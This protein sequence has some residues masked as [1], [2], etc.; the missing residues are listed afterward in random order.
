MTKFTKD[1]EKA[2]NDR[3]RDIL[4]SASA[5]SGKTTVLVERVLQEIMAGT[6]VDQLLVVTFTKAAA[7]EMKNRIKQAITNALKQKNSDTRYLRREL[8]KV[9]TAN[10]STIDAFCLDVIHRFYYVIDLDPS[11]SIL[12]DE[13]QAALLKERA[14]HEVESEYLEEKNQDFIAFYDNFAGDRDAAAPQELLLDLYDFALA[15][16]NYRNWL[17]ELSRAYDIDAEIV[18]SNLWQKEIKPY[19][20]T[21]FSALAEKI[22]A[23]LASSQMNTKELAKVYESFQLF[24]KLLANYLKALRADVSYD[25]QREL[26]QSCI[27]TGNYR[28]SNKWDEDL[29]DLYQESQDLKNQ[30]KNQIFTAFI[31]FY[32]NNEAEQLAIMHKSQKIIKTIS[33]AELALI[34]RFNEL[35]REENL[36]DYSDMEQFA[37]QILSQDTSKSQL[38]R[39]FYQNKFKEILIDEY[40]DINA[41]QEEILQLLKGPVNN[42]FMVGDVKQSIYGFRQ[43]EPDLF[44][45]KYQTFAQEDKTKERI[46]LADNFR[47]TKPVVTLVNQVFTALFDKDFGGVE[48]QKEGQLVFGAQYYPDHLASATEIIYHKKDNSVNKEKAEDDEE[49]DTAEIQMVLARIK[50]FEQEKLQVYDP[51]TKKKRPFCYSDIAILTRSRSDNLEIMQEFAKNNIPLFITDAKN[52]FQT[53]E[54]TII[55]NYL[56]IIDNPDQ[57][58]PLVTVLRSPLFNF[59]EKDL[60]KIRINS[61][62][63]SFYDALTAYISLNDQL[64]GR[65]K[66]FLNQLAELRIFAQNHRI[67]E[68]IWSIYEKT[69]LLEIMTALPNGQQ[70]RVNLEAL[71][72]RAASYESAGFK[73]LYQFINFISRMQRSQKDLAQPLL[74]KEAGNSVRLMT[75]HGSKGLEF[76]I[77]FYVGLEHKFQMRELNRDYIISP[78][79]VGLTVRQK[80]YRA[81]SLVKAIDNV[82][83]KQQLLEEEARILYVG[84]TRAKQKLI[85]VTDINNF[86]KKVG[87]WSKQVNAGEKMLLTDKLAASSPLDFVGPMLKFDRQLPQKISSITSAIDESQQLLYLLYDQPAAIPDQPNE[88]NNNQAADMTAL[89]QK[90]GQLYR[91]KYPFVDASKTTAYQAVSEIKKVFNDPLDAELENSHLLKSTNRY[92]QPIDTKPDFLFGSN[93]TGAE[94]GTATHLILQYYD[95]RGDGSSEQLNDEIQTLIKQKKL[96]PEIVASLHLDQIEWFVHSTF[97]SKFWQKPAKLKREVDFSSLLS[98]GQ[99]FPNFSDP[100]AKILVHGTIDGYYVTDQGIILFDYKTD[101]VAQ[102][103][104]ELAIAQIKQKYTGQLRLYEQA[105][106]EFSGKKVL[107]KYLILLD[108]QQVVEVK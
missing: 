20:L 39:S 104:Q 22:N 8:T 84:L 96:N 76:P 64:S 102:K 72:E 68:L 44:L 26:L 40:Q 38:A 13:T 94:I 81:D 54:L 46:L 69:S 103:N 108:A 27:F 47:S 42:L 48:Y 82:H 11:F 51:K 17:K 59:K 63:N 3:Q 41:L 34:D 70:R 25:E 79:S 80:H 23:L 91:F 83:K 57:D 30:A 105:L 1:Q 53:F 4:V 75:I 29:L 100:S 36:L 21:T 18:K 67:S 5:G 71:Y 73:G 7:E 10:F 95:Y 45:E 97:A 14:L 66:D 37:Y 2:V 32:V 12:T 93:F 49:V 58:I 99:L 98:A 78:D 43:A 19:L 28:K 89:A 6:S 62:N 92:L 77:V 87:R 61:K 24:Q 9:D 85:L 52:Y 16:P 86:D 74:T 65:I 50:Q 35:K 101:H 90:V 56:K 15:K 106:K 33:E 31:S 55:M 60:A 88:E 107:G